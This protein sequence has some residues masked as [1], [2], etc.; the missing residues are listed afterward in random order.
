MSY[1][2]PPPEHPPG[3]RCRNPRRFAKPG[4]SRRGAAGNA[5]ATRAERGLKK[6]FKFFATLPIE[7]VSQDRRL[8]ATK[9]Q[10]GER[11]MP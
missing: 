2:I 6:G 7:E 3:R 11:R 4:C 9:S 8:A 5:R 10:R 1:P